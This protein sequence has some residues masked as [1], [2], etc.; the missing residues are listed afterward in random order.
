MFNLTSSF[1]IV[2]DS[3]F[4]AKVIF[5]NFLQGI[6]MVVQKNASVLTLFLVPATHD[7]SPMRCTTGTPYFKAEVWSRRSLRRP[8]F[9]SV[10]CDTCFMH[11][12]GVVRILGSP[13]FFVFLRAIFERYWLVFS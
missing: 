1:L 13:N 8:F 7:V 10:K 3:G 12:D 9:V 4:R 6:D 11:T 5:W 2:I